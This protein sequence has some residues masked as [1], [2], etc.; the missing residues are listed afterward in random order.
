[1]LKAPLCFACVRQRDFPNLASANDLSICQ[2]CE[3]YVGIFKHE[4]N[5]VATILMA[6]F[7][8]PHYVPDSYKRN[9]GRSAWKSERPKG[10][11]GCED[12]GSSCDRGDDFPP[13]AEHRRGA[14]DDMDVAP[15]GP[16]LLS[17]KPQQAEVGGEGD[18]DEDEEEEQQE[19]QDRKELEEASTERE[20]LELPSSS[21]S[22]PLH[23]AALGRREA[24]RERLN[25]IL[26]DLLHRTPN[27]NGEGSGM[28]QG[29]RSAD[30]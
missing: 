22:S 6:P 9:G 2:P 28:K 30:D 26:L 8:Q 16:E 13:E 14:E 15:E 1:M 3:T 27:K 29:G 24:Q 4:S 23:H 25:K 10:A 19:T 17:G 18:E 7:L 20:T 11:E 12:D 5:C 21:A